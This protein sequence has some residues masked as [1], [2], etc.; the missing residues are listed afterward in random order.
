M[1]DWMSISGF[2]MNVAS[3]LDI[4]CRYIPQNV[5]APE[6]LEKIDK[7]L[8]HTK[9]ILETHGPA[10]PTNKYVKFQAMYSEYHL[11]MVFESQQDRADTKEQI[12]RGRI[13]A[14]EW[15]GN[16]GAP[17]Q[18]IGKLLDSAETLETNVLSESRKTNPTPRAF[19]DATP[20]SAGSPSDNL[21][22]GST[23]TSTA[24]TSWFSGTRASSSPTDVES[25]PV[26]ESSRVTAP[27]V[28]R[29]L[30]VSVTH[31]STRSSTVGL[32]TGGVNSTRSSL[33]RRIVTFESDERR[34]DIIDPTPHHLGGSGPYVSA[35]ALS[36]MVTLGEFIL[37]QPREA[38]LND[39]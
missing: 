25:G 39:S 19:A 17:H 23:S 11:Q 10:M 6:L 31:L 20:T 24:Y 21:P 4:G 16:L 33:Y 34:V 18:R 2:V 13:L 14:K 15:S 7:I 36:E 29:G 8:G 28:R 9:E 26:P 5:K 22:Q 35:A 38:V 30:T 12:E 3:S 37:G 1:P 27:S 32:G